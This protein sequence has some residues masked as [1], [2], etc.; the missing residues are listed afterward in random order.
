MPKKKIDAADVAAV[1]RQVGRAANLLTDYAPDHS[2]GQAVG[3]CLLV[4]DGAV[5]ESLH[6]Q[7]TEPIESLLEALYQWAKRRPGPAGLTVGEYVRGWL[8]GGSN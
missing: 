5:K 6:H 3:L 7:T 8:A 2:A 4:V 1:I